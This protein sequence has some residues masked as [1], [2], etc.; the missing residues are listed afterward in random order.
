MRQGDE[1]TLGYRV[2]QALNGQISK[3]PVKNAGK[4]DKQPAEAS[5]TREAVAKGYTAGQ[6]G[7]FNRSY[8]VNV[9]N[10]AIA[11]MGGR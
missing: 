10:K 1:N 8:P 11:K 3:Q 6:K 9:V 4:V 2:G 5:K 7:K